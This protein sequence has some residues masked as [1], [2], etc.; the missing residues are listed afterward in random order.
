MRIHT[1]CTH[2]MRGSLTAWFPERLTT[3]AGV[4][5]VASS[6]A[7]TASTPILL[8]W[9]T[10]NT[11]ILIRNT[12][13]VEYAKGKLRKR[14]GVKRGGL[15]STLSKA[16]GVPPLCTCPRIV[17]RVSKPSLFDT[18]WTRT[19]KHNQSAVKDSSYITML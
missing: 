2:S 17:A 19:E 16:D 12:K 3:Q 13:R 14:E 18:S 8:P 7:I 10:T 9:Y 6:R 11:H 1:T 5:G 15:T 4:S